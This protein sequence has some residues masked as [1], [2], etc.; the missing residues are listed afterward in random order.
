MGDSVLDDVWRTPAILLAAE[1]E[2]LRTRSSRLEAERDAA[3]ARLE[4]ARTLL[5][6]AELSTGCPNPE[7]P[8]CVARR[9]LRDTLG[10][11]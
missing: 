4:K 8:R 1:L 7:H 2:E 10:A 11:P 5:D 3:L 9:A 6:P